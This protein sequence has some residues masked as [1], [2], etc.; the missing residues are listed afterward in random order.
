MM[1]ISDS[2]RFNQ[3]KPNKEP[4]TIKEIITKMNYLE[5][6]GKQIQKE[7]GDQYWLNE[8]AKYE[9]LF[10]N[11]PDVDDTCTSKTFP[12]RWLMK[13]DVD[14]NGNLIRPIDY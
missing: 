11:H 2:N 4:M 7:K 1:S 5:D 14:I 8:V 13:D 10:V 6:N 3:T 12:W 9:D